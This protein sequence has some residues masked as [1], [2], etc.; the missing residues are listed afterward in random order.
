MA[1]QQLWTTSYAISL[2][3]L[4]VAQG[5]APE[6]A[7]LY[8]AVH[9]WMESV[10]LPVPWYPPRGYKQDEATARSA[11]G[12]EAFARAWAEGRAMTLEQ[13]VEYDLQDEV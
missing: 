2:V 8:G 13:A 7:R 10:G 9:G 6:A 4:W 1:G 12:A 3:G 11:L 5:R